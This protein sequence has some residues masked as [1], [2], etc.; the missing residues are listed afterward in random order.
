LVS[1]LT[2][3]LGLGGGIVSAFVSNL[4]SLGVKSQDTIQGL[5]K[6][7]S[8]VAYLIG[9]S[10]DT[11]SEKFNNIISTGDI[12]KSSIGDAFGM[13]Q[14]SVEDSGKSFDEWQSKFKNATELERAIMLNEVLKDNASVQEAAALSADTL[15][16]KMQ[17][18]DNSIGGV[19]RRLGE[20]VLGALGPLLDVISFAVG[21]LVDIWD[22]LP[23]P[24]K[25]FIGGI[26]LVI[27]ATGGFI[28]IIGAIGAIVPTIIS[29]LGAM[30]TATGTVSLSS[31]ATSMSLSRLD[32]ALKSVFS[33]SWPVL[34]VA[35]AIIAIVIAIQE[36]GKYMG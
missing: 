23:Q 24:I 27:A 14:Q 13:I 29:A 11:I 35:I 28:T 4:L 15:E 22:N 26:I 12:A 32:T 36:L 2:N 1:G 25:D 20:P 33:A 17:R 31:I 10:F 21:G 8:G 6:S 7:T 9:E 30:A 18:L 5:G 16:S 19:I 3:E 34:A